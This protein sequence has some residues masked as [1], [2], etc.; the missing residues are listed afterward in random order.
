MVPYLKSDGW[1]EISL[2]QIGKL[3]FDFVSVMKR[4]APIRI[5]PASQPNVADVWKV[6]ETRISCHRVPHPLDN[7]SREQG[8]DES[9]SGRRN[10]FA[11]PPAFDTPR[12][13][14]GTAQ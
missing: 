11:P 9:L 7:G 13:A 8:E 4:T 10:R 1:A 6:I 12:L 5:W 14:C 3:Q 2:R